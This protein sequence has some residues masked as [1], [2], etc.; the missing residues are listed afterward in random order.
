MVLLSSVCGGRLSSRA[1]DVAMTHL[2][3][4]VVVVSTLVQMASGSEP[5]VRAAISWV[6]IGIGCG[7]LYF[8]RRRPVTV[9]VITL[10]ACG[11][12][13]PVSVTDG[14]ALAAFAL[15]LYT[16]AAEGHFTVSVALAAATL[17]AVG[18]GEV[19][20][21][22]GHRQIDDVSVAM[23]AGWLISLVAIGRAQR[24]RLAYLHEAEQR[25][26][27]AEREQEAR[28]RQSA[29][30]ERLR[31][32]RELHD[33]LGHS[34]S[35]INVQSSAT[36]HRLS[37]KPEPP[38]ALAAAEDT[39]KAVKATSK[40][41]LRELR[42]TLGVLG[43]ADEAA[44]T[45]PTSGLDRLTE[46]ARSTGIAVRVRTEGGSRPLPPPVD[47][48]AYR[49]VQESLTNITRHADARSALVTIA[50]GATDVRLRI[51]DDGQGVDEGAALRPNVLTGAG[52]RPGLSGSGIRGMAERAKAFGGEL[53]AGNTADGFRVEARLPI[54]P[55]LS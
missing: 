31:I 23:L 34:I 54:E 10:L 8:R 13:Y 12:Y 21:N 2:V 18:F 55:S 17:L 42:G 49:I 48:A 19:V 46:R 27:A 7:A 15:A 29:T 28:A 6:L 1:A 53:T 22:S 16:L 52:S 14:P 5:P 35:L 36:L 41:A 20:I 3:T 25:A 50:Y 43:Q 24:T 9:A 11:I 38:V 44:P 30:E 4:A 45:A 40:E 51:D 39:L 47:L 37:K 26:L 33:I 32:A